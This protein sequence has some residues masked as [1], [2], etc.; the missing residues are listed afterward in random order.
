M[1]KEVAMEVKI[2]SHI[3]L[4]SYDYETYMYCPVCES[5]DDVGNYED[6]ELYF[7]YCPNCGQKLKFTEEKYL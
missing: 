4:R 2:D 6:G 1:N 5:N 7:N 3:N